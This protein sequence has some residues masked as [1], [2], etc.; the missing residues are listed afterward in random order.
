MRW[1]HRSRSPAGLGQVAGA[2]GMIP[3][4]GLLLTGGLALAQVWHT[5]VT[6]QRAARFAVNQ[7]AQAGC[8][9]DAVAQTTTGVLA[10]GGVT[11]DTVTVTAYSPAGDYGAAMSVGLRTTVPLRVLGLAL[12]ALP[13]TAVAYAPSLF[14]PAT[15][16][17]NPAGCQVPN[18]ATP[19]FALTLNASTGGGVGPYAP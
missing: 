3:L 17:A 16:G 5:T 9:T 8:W 7:E 2:I 15:P 10:G 6:L 4:V 11:P 18:A 13:L 14:V 19:A 1:L 12:T